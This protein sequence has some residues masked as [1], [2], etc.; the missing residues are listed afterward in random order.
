MGRNRR[1]NGTQSTRGSRRKRTGRPNY[2]LA[3]R[4]PFLGQGRRNYANQT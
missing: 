2:N 3:N 1:D 4:R